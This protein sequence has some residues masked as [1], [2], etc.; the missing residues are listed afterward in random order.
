MQK[1]KH[2]NSEIKII[3]ASEDYL[4]Y[5]DDIC[6]AIEN[7]A[8]NRGTGIA[9]RHPNYIKQKILQGKA[10]IAL[11]KERK[12]AGFCYIESWGKDKDFIA[13]SGL[14]VIPEFQELGLGKLIKEAAF[15]LSRSMFPFAKIFGITT[16]P[17][18][19]K[20]NFNLGYRPVTFSQLTNDNEFWAGCKSCTNFDIL[21]RTNHMQCLC[22]AMLYDPVEKKN[23]KTKE[24]IN[25]EES[26]ISI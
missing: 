3:N 8:K 14:I 23:L 10:V 24:S 20:I 17:A 22:T 26:S 5:A 25:E 11:T 12:F 6:K 9:K 15:E 21:Q 2:N 1:E 19:M 4:N 13:N 7:A 18:V 16:S